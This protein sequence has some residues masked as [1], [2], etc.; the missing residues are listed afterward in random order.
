MKLNSIQFLR[1]VA[2]LL[3]VYDHSM[4]IQ[5]N[6][7][8]S[9]QQN[10]LHINKFGNIGVDLFFVISGF[11]ITLIASRYI[12]ISQGIHFLA[13]RFCRINPV[14]YILSL[15]VLI[16]FSIPVNSI[17]DSLLILPTSGDSKAYNPVMTVG[18]TL[19]F[20]WFFYLLFFLLIVCNVRQKVL[21]LMGIISLLVI[22]GYIFKQNDFRIIFIT[23][24]IILEFLLGC[25][26]SYIY[27]NVKTIP[28]DIGF[29]C[30]LIGIAS[31]LFFIIQGFGTIWSGLATLNGHVSLN[32][33]ILWGIPGSLIVAGC[34][35]LEKNHRLKFLWNNKFMLLC[36][37]ASYSIYLVQ[38]LVLNS[39]T[40]LYEKTGYFLPADIMIWL[41]LIL[42]VAISI[43]FYQL[44]EKPLLQFMY[45]RQSRNK[46]ITSKYAIIPSDQK[47]LSTENKLKQ[48]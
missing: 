30:L 11:I 2:A 17:F 19:S 35:I 10:L 41:Q 42:A 20:E 9:L 8:I 4:L 15:L 40:L 18:W 26:I 44:V 43:F 37:D 29:S 36:G 12:G 28:V 1:A 45:K 7:G 32:R 48:M 34:V 24:P 3:V 33:A 23:N 47:G 27:L 5:T 13:K 6:Y 25:I 39:L 38:V 22:S 16:I 21:Y 14:Y 46:T 31:W